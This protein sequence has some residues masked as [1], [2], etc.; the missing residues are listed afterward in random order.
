MILNKYSNKDTFINFNHSMNKPSNLKIKLL[1]VQCLTQ[2]KM[3]ELEENMDKETIFFLTET[4]KR[5]NSV[6]NKDDTRFI[7]KTRD[8]SDKK[9]GGL[10][11]LWKSDIDMKSRELPT[12]SGDILFTENMIGSYKFYSI[13]VY[14]SVTDFKLN[15]DIMREIISLVNSIVDRDILV[16]GDFNAHIE[17]IG[18]Q[19]LNKNGKTIL[20]ILEKCDLVMLNLDDSKTTGTVTWQRG[21]QKSTIDYVMTNFSMFGKVKYMQIDECQE[22]IAISDHNLIYV[23]I[24]IKKGNKVK[25]QE[26]EKYNYFK[27]SENR[28]A[29]LIRS[30]RDKLPELASGNMELLGSNLRGLL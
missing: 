26:Y 2:T 5:D 23:N 25:T 19:K 6:R 29:N 30:I 18:Y 24:E 15:Q 14:M 27:L 20:N 28:I 10:M 16:L 4:H 12:K 8:L 13:L 1:N 11:M 9:G 21:E 22:I 17:L 3:I 7:H